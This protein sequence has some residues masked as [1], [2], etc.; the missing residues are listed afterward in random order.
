MTTKYR[1]ILGAYYFVTLLVVLAWTVNDASQTA[2]VMWTFAVIFYAFFI[3]STAAVLDAVGKS[4]PTRPA[5]WQRWQPFL[6]L[7]FHVG[8]TAF[9]CVAILLTYAEPDVGIIGSIG[10]LV[11][12]TGSFMFPVVAAYETALEPSLN[13]VTLFRLQS[14]VSMGL[15]VGLGLFIPALIMLLKTP[16]N[17]FHLVTDVGKF[18]AEQHT[19]LLLSVAFFLWLSASALFGYVPE[20]WGP[21]VSKICPFTANCYAGGN[22]LLTLAAAGLKPLIVFGVSFWCIAVLKG[23]A[24]ERAV[25]ASPSKNEDKDNLS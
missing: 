14:T 24:I 11:A 2:R 3:A 16:R 10:S 18:R 12:A 22:D 13:R 19:M 9:V 23:L 17:E 6:T 21:P 8:F 7:A 5:I 25:G 1:S 20:F 4:S 15:I